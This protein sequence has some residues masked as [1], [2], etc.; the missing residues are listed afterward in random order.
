MSAV[1]P[2][3][4][5][6][7]RE[8]ASAGEE[9]PR[10]VPWISS[11][12]FDTA[13]FFGACGI[14]LL[15]PLLAALQLVSP[16]ILVWIYVAFFD[17]PH[18]MA[19]YTRTYLDKHSRAN[20]K[21]LL[22]GTAGIGF[23]VPLFA[24]AASTAWSNEGPFALFLLAMT[25]YSFWHIVRQGWGIF[26]IYRA[27]EGERAN[28]K[29]ERAL[30]YGALYAPYIYFTFTHPAVRDAVRAPHMAH[31]WER[32]V[33]G[34][35]IVAFVAASTWLAVVL[36]RARVRAG[37]AFAAVT[38][39]YH[40]VL[41][42]VFANREPFF[43]GAQGP[44]QTFMIITGAVSIAHST[45]YIALVG[46]H[47]KRRYAGAEAA[48]G[49]VAHLA[50]SAPRYLAA[51]LAFSALYVVLT[52]ATGIYPGCGH[53]IGGGAAGAA[54]GIGPFQLTSAKIA[55]GIY[56]GIALQHYLLDAKIWRI[57]TDP[58]LRKALFR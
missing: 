28:V 32:A 49:E 51:C 39:G 3:S 45:Q 36:V 6:V 12:R 17:G 57:K 25:L 53:V 38:I 8:R 2:A 13:L 14:G 15:L 52:C 7:A 19:G 5:S 18:M 24:L 34:A 46:L 21:L 40:A 47:N 43:S 10:R 56:W 30:F 35:L 4:K 37:L 44:D 33:A 23:G 31:G 20:K 42:F 50:K 58:E 1:A 54:P 9:E 41:Y 48:H 55:L 26:A 27:R 11:A 16:V 22:W 29:R